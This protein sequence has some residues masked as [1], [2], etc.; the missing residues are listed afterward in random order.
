M[1][2]KIAKFEARNAVNTGNIGRF[3]NEEVGDF[4]LMGA[5]HDLFRGS[6]K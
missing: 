1:R 6:L 4:K 3:R 5:G 2:I